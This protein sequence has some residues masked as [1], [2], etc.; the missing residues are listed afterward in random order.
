MKEFHNLHKGERCFIIGNGPSL[1]E[2]DMEVLKGETTFG[3]NRIYLKDNFV[4]SYYVCVNPLVYEQ[5]KDEIDAIETSKFISMRCNCED[6]VYKLDTFTSWAGFYSPEESM[7]EGST[8]TFVAMQLAYYMG[9]SEVILVGVDHDFGAY[10]QPHLEAVATGPD[11][12]H[13]DPDYFSGGTRWNYPDLDMSEYAYNIAKVAFEKD[14]RKII[15]ASANTKLDVFEKVPLNH[16]IGEQP[17]V[18]AIVSAYKAE[19]FI[20]GCLEDQD[21]QSEVP[22]TVVVCQ[23]G[24]VEHRLALENMFCTIVT[25]KNIPTVYHAWNLGIR[26]AS[27]KYIT[28]ANTD[29]RH[30]P[31]AYRMMADLLDA[32]ADYDLVY[33]SCY[34]TWK[35]QTFA[36]FV[37]E[38]EGKDLK[39]G[40]WEGEPGLFM[41]H[42]YNRGLLGKGCFIGPQP[43]WRANLHQ[44]H[45]YFLDNYKSAGDY[46]FWLRIAKDA[47]MYRLPHVLGLYHAR[48]DGIELGNP[49][50]NAREAETAI[51]MHQE[52]EGIGFIPTG[53]YV[54]A[55]MGGR[56][57]FLE[58]GQLMGVM[59]RLKAEI[60]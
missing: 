45:G 57:T 33:H 10:K 26:A 36:D 52:P 50:N 40:R 51:V 48:A 42:E 21:K 9:F 41:W 56:W 4:P 11:E 58:N 27:G 12:H 16:L 44:R 55:E 23:E 25:T 28:N 14:G 43:M 19:E 13:F 24:S 2:V 17:R 1:N 20:K 29:D 31:D 8:V 60:K 47:N 5:F 32:R 3:T 30:H 15:N 37:E 7:W 35:D 22:E 59:E 39:M 54:R 34:I 18:S 38:N 53:D 46:E 6:D 49:M